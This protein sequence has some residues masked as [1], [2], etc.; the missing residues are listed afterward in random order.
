MEGM[1]ETREAKE[2]V[3]GSIAG[4]DALLSSGKNSSERTD[5]VQ[6]Y[7]WLILKLKKAMLST[8]WFFLLVIAHFRILWIKNSCFNEEIFLN[9][10]MFLTIFQHRIFF[11]SVFQKVWI[12]FV[13]FAFD[14][15]VHPKASRSSTSVS[16]SKPK[17]L[18]TGHFQMFLRNLQLACISSLILCSRL[19]IVSLQR[20]VWIYVYLFIY[21]SVVAITFTN[22]SITF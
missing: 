19:L 21:Y 9:W 16:F 8:Y 10:I 1:E 13:R 18:N 15:S 17:G 22:L 12:V 3:E 7:T 6:F 4:T 2:E 20:S 11:R 14:F 5:F